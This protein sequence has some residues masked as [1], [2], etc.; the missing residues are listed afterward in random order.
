[1]V[2]EY[3]LEP[4]CP[5]DFGGG[6]DGAQ[7]LHDVHGP[8]GLHVVDQ[9]SRGA[10][11]FLHEVRAHE[12]HPERLVLHVDGAIG[13]EYGN[14]RRFCLAQHGFPPGL[15]DWGK[16]N[17]IDLSRDEGPDC[18]DLFFRLPFRV[19]ED[20]IDPCLPR[21]GLDGLRVRQT[22]VA[23]RPGLGETRARC[24]DRVSQRAWTRRKAKRAALDRLRVTRE[25]RRI[26]FFGMPSSWWRMSI[27]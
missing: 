12:G 17:D 7:Q 8:V 2:L 5:V 9:P 19:D 11:P 21:R 20:E 3:L 23:L 6:A 27:A 13:Q 10:S 25:V 1:M 26:I 14:A 4:D 15:D 24:A 22:P 18:G 16:G